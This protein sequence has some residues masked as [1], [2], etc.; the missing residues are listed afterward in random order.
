MAETTA[1]FRGR[2]IV[3]SDDPANPTVRIDGKPVPVV[4]SDQGFAVGYLGPKADLMEAAKDFA[5]L[6]PNDG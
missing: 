6:M 1:H 2:E 4:H 5:R 3:V